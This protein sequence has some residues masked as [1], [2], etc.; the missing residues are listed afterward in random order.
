MKKLRFRHAALNGCGDDQLLSHV[1]KKVQSD[2]IL[3]RYNRLHNEENACH[4]PAG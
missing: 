4:S 3:Y 1:S 2:S